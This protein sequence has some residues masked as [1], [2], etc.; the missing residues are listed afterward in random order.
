MA[1][2]K[3]AKYKYTKETAIRDMLVRDRVDAL[4]K[5]LAIADMRLAGDCGEEER[6]KLQQK[7]QQAE[8]TLARAKRLLESKPCPRRRA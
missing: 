6:V 3:F 2:H 8:A 4:K 1:Q 5:F 7:R